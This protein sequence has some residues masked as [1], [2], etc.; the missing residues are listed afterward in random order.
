[1]PPEQTAKPRSRSIWFATGSILVGIASVAGVAGLITTAIQKVHTGHGLDTFRTASRLV[2]FNWISILIVLG[3][4]VI[5][6]LVAPLLFV[7]RWSGAHSRRSM[8]ATQRI[9]HNNS[10]KPNPF[11]GSA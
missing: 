4:A 11:R 9:A 3:A 10:F 8:D 1:M 6:V 2:E 7:S 5:G